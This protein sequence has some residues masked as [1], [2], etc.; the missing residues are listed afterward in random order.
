M[1]V[2]VK[3]VFG[4]YILIQTGHLKFRIDSQ[5]LVLQNGVLIKFCCT[6]NLEDCV[7]CCDLLLNKYSPDIQDHA[8]VSNT[9][10][11]HNE[12]TM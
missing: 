4:E 9:C 6:A 1:A 8:A 12:H 10:I 11:G 5:L 2:D 3:H 7:L